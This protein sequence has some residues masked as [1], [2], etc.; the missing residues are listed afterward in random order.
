M[1]RAKRCSA[2]YAKHASPN[3]PHLRTPLKAS[4]PREVFLRCAPLASPSA[5]IHPDRP[6][7]QA[8]QI[9]QVMEERSI[10]IDIAPY[11]SFLARRGSVRP[12]NAHFQITSMNLQK[13]MRQHARSSAPPEPER[14]APV[15]FIVGRAFDQSA[16]HFSKN[17]P[18][19]LGESH[20]PEIPARDFQ[21]MLQCSGRLCILAARH[22]G[23]CLAA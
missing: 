5:T 18:K 15:R 23:P 10:H 20:W 19:F 17:R 2:S 6:A 3:T 13:P 4:P 7:R 11:P 12:G 8:S 14:H 22:F 1:R 9:A 21:P 16:R